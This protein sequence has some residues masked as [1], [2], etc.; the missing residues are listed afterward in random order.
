MCCSIQS[1]C[2]SLKS[3]PGIVEFP[4]SIALKFRDCR[5]ILRKPLI[6]KGEY[7]VQSLPGSGI[8]LN[9]FLHLSGQFFDHDA[10]S[11]NLILMVTE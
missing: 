6:H 2:E 8:V 10:L 11:R 9:L 1:L 7:S 4:L 5:L 3:L